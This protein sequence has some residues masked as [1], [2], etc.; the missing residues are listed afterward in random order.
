[1]ENR[2]GTSDIR[3]KSERR[4]QKLRRSD[5]IL[6][7][8]QR[9]FGAAEIQT[10]IFSRTS[11]AAIIMVETVSRRVRRS[12][13]SG[14]AQFFHGRALEQ[15]VRAVARRVGASDGGL[16]WN[17]FWTTIAFSEFWFIMVVSV[18]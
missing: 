10:P 4:S 5:S 12:L 8:R 11:A 9:R 6:T 18:L 7:V 17:F 15:L 13:K 1:M 2:V 3:E 14:P 16:E